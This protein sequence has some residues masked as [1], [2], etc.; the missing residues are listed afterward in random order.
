MKPIYLKGS[1]F[2]AF[3][4]LISSLTFG[5]YFGKN[6]PK[7]EN[8]DFKVAETPHFDI[9]YYFKNDSLLNTLSEDAEKWYSLHQEVFHDSVLNNNPILFYNNHADFQQTNAIG[10]SISG[11]TGGVTE[12]FK[13]RVIMPLAYSNQQTDHVLGHEMVHAFQYSLILNGSDSTNL[14]S[15]GNLPLWMVEGLAEYMSVGR[16]DPHTAMWLRDAVLNDDVPE[17]KDLNNPKYFPYRWGQ[18][19]WS[20]IT[21]MKGDDIIKPLF[22]STAKYGLKIAV[23][24]EVGVNWKIYPNF[25]LI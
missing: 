21:G 3:F 22:L 7:Y 20:F 5:Q 12:A 6:K 11:G 23:Q 15:L 25:G 13:N 18:A 16:V 8:F 9:Y 10:G 17:I 24:K 4:L 1:L 14:E 2:F 19:F